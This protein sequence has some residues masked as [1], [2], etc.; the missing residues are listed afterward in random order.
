MT[1]RITFL[2]VKTREKRTWHSSWP[3]HHQKI[4]GISSNIKPNYLNPKYHASLP[5]SLPSYSNH[6]SVG[7]DS[8][9][10]EAPT[11]QTSQDQERDSIG[12]Q[13]KEE[14]GGGEDEEEKRMK[15]ETQKTNTT[16]E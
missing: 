7:Q 13:R 9:S 10:R 1:K 14:G 8:Q 16:K 6:R 4:K 15:M 3:K 5:A 12:N 11:T 2:P